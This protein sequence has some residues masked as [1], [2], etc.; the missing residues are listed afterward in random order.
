MMIEHSCCRLKTP[1]TLFTNTIIFCVIC[2]RILPIIVDRFFVIKC[3]T[4][5][6]RL[7]SSYQQLGLFMACVLWRRLE[8]YALSN[9]VEYVWLNHQQYTFSSFHLNLSG[10][11][12][13]NC[14]RHLSW[15]VVKFCTPKSEKYG[16]VHS[17]LLLGSTGQWLFVSGP[18]SLLS[19]S[20]HPSGRVKI[21]KFI[22]KLPPFTFF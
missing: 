21:Q 2:T 13:V 19:C 11:Y 4:T 7:A 3:F 5:E 16:I 15:I 17:T 12:C 6:S 20:S 1:S 10:K 14:S 9:V 8:K 22:T 18:L